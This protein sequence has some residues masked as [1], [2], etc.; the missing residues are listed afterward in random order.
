MN[1]E[2]DSLLVPALPQ[3]RQTLSDGESMHVKRFDTPYD[4]QIPTLPLKIL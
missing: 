4:K 2:K 3:I 1:R